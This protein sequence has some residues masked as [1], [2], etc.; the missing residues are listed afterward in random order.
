LTSKGRL[1]CRADA[2]PNAAALTTSFV[3]LFPLAIRNPA[4]VVFF[5]NPDSRVLS[6]VLWE[7]WTGRALEQG[8]G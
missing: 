3:L 5:Y 1:R 8:A 4:L 6:A 2:D 7:S